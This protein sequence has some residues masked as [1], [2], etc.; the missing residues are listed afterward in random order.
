MVEGV[1]SVING[2]SVNA[3]RLVVISRV[4]PSVKTEGFSYILERVA[5]SFSVHLFHNDYRGRLVYIR[6]SYYPIKGFRVDDCYRAS[7]FFVLVESFEDVC[8]VGGVE[9]DVV[10]CFNFL[11]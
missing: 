11:R 8:K 5:V 1:A 7:V 2:H 9:F 6:G 4:R 10:K 3:L